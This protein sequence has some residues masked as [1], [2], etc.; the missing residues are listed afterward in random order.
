MQVLASQSKPLP[1]INRTAK[2]LL[3]PSATE[4]AQ[5]SGL[6]ELAVHCGCGWFD[7]SYELNTGLQVTE[8][9]DPSLLQLWARVLS[10]TMARH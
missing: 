8:D 2:A 9:Q 5:Q 7:S 6:K 1:M 3:L 10:G 4:E